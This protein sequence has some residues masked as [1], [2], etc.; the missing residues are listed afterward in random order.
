MASA[1]FSQFVVTTANETACETS[2]DKSRTFP[3]LPVRST[4]QGYGCLWD[5]AAFGQLIRL[6]RLVIGFLFVGPRFRYG[7]FSPPPHGVKLA[8]RYRVRRQLRPL[9]LPPKLRDMPVIPKPPVTGKVTGR[10][11][12]VTRSTKHF[13]GIRINSSC[14]NKK[15]IGLF[16][17]FAQELQESIPNLLCFQAAGC[18]HYSH[19]QVFLSFTFH[20][21]RQYLPSVFHRVL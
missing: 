14:G 1:D 2:R 21:E 9:G 3:R 13:N 11:F 10:L 5:F 18:Q 19:I 15:R 20:Q 16:R 12:L 8:N 17:H 6:L 7:F 4:Q